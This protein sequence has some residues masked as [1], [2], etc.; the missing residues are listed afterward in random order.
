MAATYY[1]PC[2]RSRKMIHDTLKL[3]ERS[4]SVPA[5]FHSRSPRRAVGRSVGLLVGRRVGLRVGFRKG[6]LVGFLV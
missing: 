6:F 4:R 2:S 5:G 1:L 3:W